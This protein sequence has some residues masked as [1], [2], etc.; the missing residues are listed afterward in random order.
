M[1]LNKDHAKSIN[2]NF[3]VDLFRASAQENDLE[4]MSTLST[5]IIYTK[6]SLI[7]VGI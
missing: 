4:V 6:P 2:L 5:L 1:V 3:P 7:A